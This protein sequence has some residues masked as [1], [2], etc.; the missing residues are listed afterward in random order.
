M[1]KLSKIIRG[2]MT[3]S[4]L[5]ARF[6]DEIS[7]FGLYPKIQHP[8]ECFFLDFAFPEN[9][10]AIEID[11]SLYHNNAIQGAKDEYKDSRLKKNGWKIER[12]PGWIIY[13]HKELA[14]SKIA[15]RYFMD[16][17]TNIQRNHALGIIEQFMIRNFGYSYV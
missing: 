14:A 11:G 12:F 15:L 1:R 5:E 10:L 6:L 2:S 17:L 7:W 8:F 3:Q 16:K 9:K 4:P 13:R